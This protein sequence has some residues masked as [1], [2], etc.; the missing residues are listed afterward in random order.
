VGLFTVRRMQFK[1]ARNFRVITSIKTGREDTR[2]RTAA[3]QVNKVGVAS[4]TP[5]HCDCL[6]MDWPPSQRRRYMGALGGSRCDVARMRAGLS[7]SL[8]GLLLVR[9]T[10]DDRQR[11]AVPSA[12]CCSWTSADVVELVVKSRTVTLSR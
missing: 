5:I 7:W 6:L 3:K 2:T 10:C 9:R 4:V 1:D 11:G 12:G 8:T